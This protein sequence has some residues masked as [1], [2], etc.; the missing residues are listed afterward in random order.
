MASTDLRFP[1]RAEHRGWLETQAPLPA[2]FRVGPTRFTS[3]P[4]EAASPGRA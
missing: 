3:R 4:G 2:G 1:T